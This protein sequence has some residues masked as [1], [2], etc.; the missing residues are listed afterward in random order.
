M[1]QEFVHFILPQ[2]LEGYGAATRSSRSSWCSPKVEFQLFGATVSNITLVVIAAA[3]I[4]A[5]V[6]DIAIHRTKFGRGY[7]RWRRDPPPRP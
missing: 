1:L 4:L 6:T 5:A 3:T 2:L 7:E